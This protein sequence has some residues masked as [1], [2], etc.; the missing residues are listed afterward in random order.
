MKILMI[1]CYPPAPG[2]GELQTQVQVRE[3]VKRGHEVIVIDA[4][5][6]YAN[7]AADRDGS[8]PVI[9]IVTPGI[10]LV[11]SAAYHAKLAWHVFRQGRGAHVAQ[12]NN[13]GTSVAVSVPLL[14]LMRI[15]RILVIWG[16][17][18]PEDQ[19]FGPGW[20]FVLFRQLARGVERVVSLATSSIANLTKRRFPS[21]RIVF[22]PNGVDTEKFR[23]RNPG[24]TKVLPAGWPNGG[25]VVISVGRLVSVKG[26]DVLFEAWATV[27]R[28]HP[29]A[30]L[31][32]AGDGPLRASL[33]D[34]AAALGIADQV[35][36][37]GP[38]EDVPEL[39]R[40]ADVYVSSSRSEGMSN[41]ILEALA[42]GLPVVATRAGA[43]DDIIDDGVTGVLIPSGNPAAIAEALTA[44]LND[45]LRR[46]E[47]AEE[48]RAR[49]LRDF[50]VS[51]VVDRYLQLYQELSST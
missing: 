19:P 43:E 36:L 35:T 17:A 25:P 46:R 8:I 47:L 7:D 18:R 28:Q 42:A 16:S 40:A 50:Q 20:R 3:M 5:A 11:R 27:L 34:Q 48:A 49:V 12:I 38:R 4:L 14:G 37:L 21:D 23:P 51:A 9:R 13:V 22:I 10:P 41:S 24:E 33:L 15:P 1:S 6:R 2:G 39:L 32:I 30:R 31:V 26:F 29:R 45:P 44:L